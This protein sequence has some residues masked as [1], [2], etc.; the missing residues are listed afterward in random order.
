MGFQ[1]LDVL[2]N[3]LP[4]QAVFVMNERRDAGGVLHGAM[5][6]STTVNNVRP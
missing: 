5:A 6:T 1:R 4:R 2:S 3:I